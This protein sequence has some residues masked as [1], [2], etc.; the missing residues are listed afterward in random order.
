M[1]TVSQLQKEKLNIAFV[2]PVNGIAG[3]NFIVYLQARALRAAGHDVTIIF[4]TIKSGIDKLR[5][6]KDFDVNPMHISEIPQGTTFDV[7]IATWWGTFFELPNISATKY[8]YF[9]QSDERR[10]YPKEDALTRAWVEMTYSFPEIGIITEAKWIKNLMSDEFDLRAVY[11]PNGVDTKLFSPDVKP[12]AEKGNRLR[13]L[14]E[15]PGAVDFKRVHDAF[16]ITGE[17][18]EVE[19]WYVCSDGVV[20]PNWLYEKLFVSV[21]FT[22]MPAIYRSCDI[23]IKVSAVEGFFGPPLE[24]LATGGT[25]I[26]SNV[27]G[28]DEYIRNGHNAIVIPIGDVKAGVEALRRLVSDSDLR[29][30][31]A[32]N[33]RKTAIEFDWNLQHPK[34]EKGLL[35]LYSRT[36]PA[37]Q[38]LKRRLR[39]A[40]LLRETPP[41]RFRYKVAD[42][43][44]NK[45]ESMSPALLKGLRTLALKAN[46]IRKSVTSRPSQT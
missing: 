41:S 13:V 11:A 5:H 6:F 10:F 14:I 29:K 40:K 30:Q 3:G 22:D 18:P 42:G 33:G 4:C 38:A 23:L 8:F 31:L 44:A 7:A 20:K 26:V 39:L 17:V 35:E 43:I 2:L 28:H 21:P 27:T 37:T 15:G 12:L 1:T 24:M 25:C 36:P 19:V 34:F 45:M 16:A 46:H 9:V 32:A